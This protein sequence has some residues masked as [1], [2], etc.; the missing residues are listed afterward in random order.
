MIRALAAA[1][2]VAAL[3]SA[4]LGAIAAVAGART[5]RP[6]LVRAAERAVFVNFWLL[7]IANLAMVYALVTHDFSVSYVAQ[8]GSRSTGPDRIRCCRTTS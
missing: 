2:I 1:A 3:V 5:R 6:N 7:T 4:V 8:V